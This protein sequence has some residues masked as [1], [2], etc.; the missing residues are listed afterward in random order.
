MYESHEIIESF[1]IRTGGLKMIIVSK[2]IQ[3]LGSET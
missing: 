2:N 1:E 3:L